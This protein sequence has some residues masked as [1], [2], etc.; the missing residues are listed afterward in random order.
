MSGAAFRGAPAVPDVA[1]CDCP[2]CEGK[3]AN[4]KCSRCKV[5]YYCNA[6]CQRTHWKTHKAECMQFVQHI[7]D[8]EKSDREMDQF[9]NRSVASV[10][11]E[12]CVCYEP[13]E[14]ISEVMQ[15]QCKHVFCLSCMFTLS[16]HHDFQNIQCPLCRT[17][18]GAD[19]INQIY[20]KSTMFLQRAG[21]AK[22]LNREL[23]LHY[24]QLATT[25][26]SKLGP[27]QDYTNCGLNGMRFVSLIDTVRAGIAVLEGNYELAVSISKTAL[28]AIDSGTGP[29]NM[30]QG[31]KSELLGYLHESL[32]ELGMYE[33]A[34]A[35]LRATFDLFENDAKACRQA[36]YNCSRIYYHM[37]QYKQA[38]NIA[39]GAVEMNRHYE[40]VYKYIV[41]SYRAL[42]DWDSAIATQR[43][44]VRYDT[45]WDPRRTALLVAEL[46]ELVAERKKERQKAK[47]KEKEKEEEEKVAL[48]A[49]GSSNSDDSAV[50]TDSPVA[51]IKEASAINNTTNTRDTATAADDDNNNN[52]VSISTG[53]GV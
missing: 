53:N 36:L 14:E 49:V 28:D 33:E 46:E 39:G 37:G 10:G 15:L 12:C 20:H 52:N 13:I 24:C 45:P 50:S 6:T 18:I 34:L 42:G 40:D 47:E 19:L 43:L 38:I 2:N 26:L 25:E 27:A 29:N 32:M 23:M 9:V 51:T 4:L 30:G 3:N 22:R 48:A 35:S 44:A 17:D 7:K 31:N 8:F 41:L 1:L 5:V 11:S 16:G 21:R